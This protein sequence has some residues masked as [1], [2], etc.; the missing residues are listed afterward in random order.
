MQ[1]SLTFA[2]VGKSPNAQFDMRGFDWVIYFCKHG[3]LY[4]ATLTGKWN[5]PGET[6]TVFFEV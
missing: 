1:G 4:D 3:I 6:Q 2:Q 5:P